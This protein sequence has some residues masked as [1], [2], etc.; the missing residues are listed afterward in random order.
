[1]ITAHRLIV[2]DTERFLD[3][4][5]NTVLPTREYLVP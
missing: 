2:E 5:K 1:M 3:N 4:D